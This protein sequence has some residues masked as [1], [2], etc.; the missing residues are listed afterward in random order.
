VHYPYV[1]SSVGNA[2]C[3]CLSENAHTLLSAGQI[4]RTERQD[5]INTAY[6]NGRVKMVLYTKP[7]FS[8]LI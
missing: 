2:L 7:D 1:V 3:R 8:E 4:R 6:Y 5:A